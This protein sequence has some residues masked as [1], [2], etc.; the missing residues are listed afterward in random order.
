MIF[1][2]SINIFITL[3]VNYNDM[4]YFRTIHLQDKDFLFKILLVDS[5]DEDELKRVEI[6]MKA[7]ASRER[8]KIFSLLLS[9]H[10]EFLSS[11]EI[12]KI[13]KINSNTVR[14][15][16]KILREANLIS[17]EKHNVKN[18]MDAWRYKSKYCGLVFGIDPK[19]WKSS[20]VISAD[21]RPFIP[22]GFIYKKEVD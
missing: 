10:P 14:F 3:Q 8:I 21:S 16:L 2:V 13:T 18:N 11:K 12:S 22:K 5:S 20:P 17:S 1:F 9:K 6:K 19:N 4:D 15:H 7:L